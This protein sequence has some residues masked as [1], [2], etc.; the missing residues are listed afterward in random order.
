MSVEFDEQ[1][2]KAAEYCDLSAMKE[3]VKRGANVN[4]EDSNGETA[5]VKIAGSTNPA[6][7]QAM[8]YLVE[9]GAIVNCAKKKNI[10]SIVV[11]NRNNS[12][13][14]MLNYLIEH[15]RRHPD[16]SWGRADVNARGQGQLPA[17]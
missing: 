10:L 14:L 11:V 5:L 15:G 17:T 6:A 8:T 7:F 9:K 2:L 4:A 13:C 12:A 3:A 16:G 1:L